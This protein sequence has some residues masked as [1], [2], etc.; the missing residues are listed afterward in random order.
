VGRHLGA[1]LSGRLRG[2]GQPLFSISVHMYFQI[3]P[4]PPTSTFVCLI[5]CPTFESKRKLLSRDFPL[6]GDGN[7]SAEGMGQ[8][9][10]TFFSSTATSL[11]LSLRFFSCFFFYSM[12]MAAI[13]LNVMTLDTGL[14]YLLD[15]ARVP[16]FLQEKLAE[17]DI[18]TLAQFVNLD[19]DKAALRALLA[20]E[21][22]YTAANHQGARA[23]VAAFLSAWD[24]ATIRRTK[25]SEEAAI[26]KTSRLPRTLPNSEHLILRRAFI[27]K[28]VKNPAKFTNAM[29]PS[30]HYIEFRLSLIEGGEQRAESLV[31][32]TT[33]ADNE[34]SGGG[35][36]ETLETDL[37]LTIGGNI[38]VTKAPKDGRLPIDT[39]ELRAKIRV[40]GNTWIF[41]AL[42]LS[43]RTELADIVPAIFGDYA[44]YLC[45]D[46][47]LKHHCKAPG[48]EILSTPSMAQVIEYD[49]QIRTRLADLMNEGATFVNALDEAMG[50]K[51]VRDR[52][53]FSQ[54]VMGGLASA[55][56]EIRELKAAHVPH[57]ARSPPRK[58]PR[59]ETPVKGAGKYQNAWHVKGK[60]AG[61]DG[62]GKGKGKDG[63]GKAKSAKFGAKGHVKGRTGD[64]RLICFAFNGDGCNGQHCNMVHVCSTCEGPHAA[65]DPSCPGYVAARWQ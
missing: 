65:H 60:G 35:Q 21:W 7:P 10:N 41:A 6:K 23:G 56:N 16:V 61:K 55:M 50:D 53:F 39:E 13:N 40:W 46:R 38:R 15:E 27:A 43:T 34:D 12:A 11:E 2:P 33:R 4:R 25:E 58:Q 37:S 28:Y 31:K 47:V 17:E 44:D 19:S 22:G 63:K 49:F 14:R 3:L 20:D 29:C 57:R 59:Y 54:V 5:F 18:L 36:K 24:D 64:K 26:A 9:E 30:S 32:V 45:G 8:R 62:K 51:E 42:R 1:R 48:G 52:G